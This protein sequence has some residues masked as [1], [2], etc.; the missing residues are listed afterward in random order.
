MEFSEW[1]SPCATA[2]RH[3]QL[4]PA[5]A[6]SLVAALAATACGDDP[7]D[8]RRASRTSSRSVALPPRDGPSPVRFVDATAESGV[9]FNH[10]NGFGDQHWLIVETLGSGVVFFDADR[11]GDQDLYFLTGRPCFSSPVGPTPVDTFFRN[12]GHGHF[13]D[14]TQ[15]TGLADGHYSLGACAA[16]YDNDGD[17][18]LYVTHFDEANA[19]FQNDGAG[20]F[21]E[22][23]VAAGVAGR[24][25]AIDAVCAFADVDNDGWLDLYVG[26]YADATKTSPKQCWDWPAGKPEQ[27]ARRY[28][29]PGDY[30]PLPDL[31]FRNRGDGTFVDF[32]RE[33]GVG[34]LSG[35]TL[36]LA[37]CDFDDDHDQDLVVASDRSPNFLLVNDGAGHFVDHALEAGI[38]VNADGRSQAGMGVAVGDWSGD[39]RLDLVISYFEREPYGI[40][41]QQG[42]HL[43]QDAAQSAGTADA[44]YLPLGWGTEL[45]DADLDGRLDWMIVNGHLQPDVEKLHAATLH[46]GYAQLPLFFLNRGGGLFESL[47]AEAGPAMEER[48]VGRGLALADFDGDG[49]QDVAINCNRAAAVVMRN[50]SP[51]GDRHWLVVRTVGT[52]SNRDGIG[53]RVVLEAG[54]TTQLRE[55][56]T[57]QSYLSQSEL[58]ASF[59]LGAARVATRVEVRWPSGRVSHLAEVAA[60]QVLTVT[61]PAE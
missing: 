23:A 49:D 54:G 56:H 28:C 3:S 45:F 51:R 55:I 11:D 40:Y 29:T 21:V 39:G 43:F 10:D 27:K 2:L 31:L 34:A 22:V 30:Q 13:S 35:R 59:G 8:D 50:D 6:L 26:A 24:P 60:D 41:R 52:K 42:D 61:E 44:T 36:G 47:A 12:D 4:A 16:D 1:W 9:T 48:L 32:T 38:A 5:I 33:S 37:F 57:A 17:L 7:S 58:A 46:A 19:L 18:D 20:H 15:E 25:D 53:A 14:A